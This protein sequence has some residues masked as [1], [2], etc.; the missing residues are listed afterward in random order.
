MAYKKGKLKDL[1][2]NVLLPKTSLD[3]IVLDTTVSGS[4]TSI[5]SG[6]KIK[7]DYISLPSSVVTTSGG[8]ISTNVLPGSV[9]QTV[10][11]V[12]PKSLLPGSVDDIVELKAVAASA[13]SATGV[14][15][16]DQW[17][18]TTT[19]KVMT[20]VSAG[21]WSGATSS[22][23]GDEFIYY[24]PTTK[25]SY[26]WSGSAMVEIAAMI[27]TTTEVRDS[28]D[29]SD[30]FVPTE[31]A[32][33]SVVDSFSIP[34]AT[35]NEALA[36]SSDEKVVSP[37]TLGEVLG[38]R[39]VMLVNPNI[40]EGAHYYDSPAI[41]ESYWNS[42]TGKIYTATQ[43][44]SWTN[45]VTRDPSTNVLYCVANS[46][47]R[48]FYWYHNGTMSEFI[49]NASSSTKGLASFSS[50]QFDVSSAGAVSIKSSILGAKS[51]TTAQR[52]ATTPAAGT[53]IY[54]T[55]LEMLYVGDGTTAGGN[56]ISSGSGGGEYT[57]G[58]R[59]KIIGGSTIA[60]DPW[61]TIENLG[62]TAS[63]T[64]YAGHA[65]KLLAT[66]GTHTLAVETPQ[67]G[68]YG[69]DA[70]IELFVGAATMVQT[71]N[72]LILMDP[73]VPDAVNDCV[74]K[75]RDGE[76]LMYVEDHDYGYV[77]TVAG[78]TAGTEMN[79]SLYYGLSGNTNSYLVFNYAVNGSA[80]DLGG[81]VTNG[82]KHVVGNGYTDTILTGGVSCTSKT[83]F[84]NLGMSSAFV[85]GGTM[86]LGDVYIP[87]G[88]IVSVSGGRL[89]IEKVTG[90]GGLIDLGQTN[91]FI[92]SGGSAYASGCTF[93]NGSASQGGAISM[94]TGANG[95]TLIDCV[96]S[97]NAVSDRA[98]H[99]RFGGTCVMSNCVIGPGTA[100]IGGAEDLRVSSATLDITG[101]TTGH[102]ATYIQAEIRLHGSNNI[103]KIGES[104]S[105]PAN[106]NNI[107]IDSGASISLSLLLNANKITVLEGGCTVNGT[108][109][110]A[111][112]YTRITSSG[113]SAVAQ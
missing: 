40:N 29:A 70:H 28:L 67:A 42:S 63:A 27:A 107:T 22:D 68:K 103:T 95:I 20:A 86:T 91:I 35:E 77:I 58:W 47:H 71:Q 50:S 3:S 75:F 98:K 12:I 32:V 72:P 1:G 54:D 59:T 79:G 4:T 7:A 44:G 78:G 65:Y 38:K 11:G 10:N 64:L 81:A 76:A 52:T 89:E 18:N 48:T 26:R 82:E 56:V 39:I 34:F 105:N 17:F 92:A 53:L 104:A 66:S 109:I 45:A 62:S 6:G 23:P 102:I 80:C 36:T 69:M 19:G 90:S 14:A 110:P 21:S 74:V 41:G 15:D 87:N 30:D 106:A 85:T 43:A 101:C 5:A 2:G 93:T 57:A 83:T 100:S 88:G 94:G 111:G 60:L 49:P 84:T 96:F 112:E 33:R 25:K 99:I 46:N 108:A 24:V 51:M 55:D 8:V 37:E 16:G 31:A 97:G 113:G 9:V 61:T 13:P 73:L